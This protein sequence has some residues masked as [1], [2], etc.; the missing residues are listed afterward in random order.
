MKK[1]SDGKWLLSFMLALLMMLVMLPVTCI[2]VHAQ[3]T[4]SDDKYLTFTGTADFKLT[5]SFCEG[6][7]LQYATADPD[8]DESWKPVT[9]GTEI[10]VRDKPYVL[11]LRG[12]DNSDKQ[13]FSYDNHLSIESTGNVA[14]S[15]NIMTL[16]DY[17]APDQAQM[18]A[19]CFSH[20]FYNC[21]ALTAAP[22][23]PATELAIWCYECMFMGCSSL[24]TAP[25]LPA[26]KMK[27]FCYYDM[28]YDCSSL[29]AAPELPATTLAFSCYGNMFCNCSSL[30]A[31]PELRA[32][33]LVESCCSNMFNGCTGIRL[34]ENLTY[35]YDVP[36]CIPSYG[37]ETLNLALNDM[38]KGTGGTFTDTPEPGKTYY[39]KVDYLTFTAEEGGSS[40][41]IKLK[42]GCSPLQY[43]KKENG[44][45]TEWTDYTNNTSITLDRGDNVRFR[46]SDNENKQLFDNK[47]HVTISGKV[48]CSGNI[49]TL[50]DYKHPDQAKI[51]QDCFNY[52]FYGCSSLTAAPA[53]P[54]TE[55]ADDCYWG[56]FGGC[57]S[58][59]A[60]PAL[61]ATE[62][63]KGCYDGMFSGCSSL[64]EVPALPA[65]ELAKW[66]YDGM[67]YGCS[68]LIAAPALPAE[69]LA[70][71]CY[72]QM[73]AGCSSL[74][75]A[76]ALPATKLAKSCYDGMFGG[77]SSL[78]EAPELPATELSE[79]CYNGM[80]YG[81]SS[82]TA[83][84]ALPA[85]ELSEF[86]YS[87]MFSGCSSLTEAPALPA[88]K[89]AKKC[90]Y[91]MFS[92][93]TGI[94]LSVTQTDYFTDEY[95]VPSSGIGTIAENAL[96]GMFYGTGG[97]FKSTPDINTTYYMDI[98][99]AKAPV[100]TTQP[101]DLTLKYGASSGNILGVQAKVATG[102]AVSYQWYS[103]TNSNEDG[104]AIQNATDCCYTIPSDTAIGT[105][106][107]YCVITAT[108]E[109]SGKTAEAVSNVAA[110]SVGK[111]VPTDYSAPIL[112]G[113]SLSF[114]GSALYLIETEGST[115]QG[116]LYYAVTESAA[117]PDVWTDNVS[118]IT[119][120]KTGKF[121]VWYKI[122][123]ENYELTPTKLGEV[124]VT[125]VPVNEI[126]LNEDNLELTVGSTV[127]LTA[128]VTPDNATYP[129]V[130]WTSDKESVA[131]VENGVIKAV[132]AGTATITATAGGKSATCTVTVQPK[133]IPVTGISL[134]EDT[135]ELTVGDTATL[136]ATVAPDDTT[137]PAVTWT[138]DTESVATVENGV[139]TAVSAGTATITATAG[140][141]SATCTVT[142]KAKNNSGYIP[143]TP[144][145]PSDDKNNTNNDGP[146]IVGNGISGWD[147]IAA[148]I[149]KTPEGG[150][151]T[152][153]M[154][155]ATT[156]PSSV[157]NAV[158][159]KNVDIILDMDDGIKWTINGKSVTY[160]LWNI[161][162]GVTV[163]KSGIPVKVINNITGE[164]YNVVIS[165]AHNGPFGFKATL[166]I[167]MRR[168]DAGL[169]ANLFYY[170]RTTKKLEYV[171]GGKIMDDGSVSL[172]FNHASDY[173][174]IVDDHILGKELTAK[175]GR[176]GNVKLSWTA[177]DSAE[178]Y[179]VY[180]VIDGKWVKLGTTTKTTYTVKGLK[181][182]KTCKFMVR[183]NV[184][185]NL[186]AKSDSL[187]LKLKV[188][189][190]PA[191]KATKSDGKLTLTWKE[192]PGA[193]KYRIYVVKND[194]LVKLKNTKLLTY[195]M[196]SKAGKTYRFA[197]KAYVN[198]KWTRIE[199]SDIIKVKVK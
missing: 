22:A 147:N 60:A 167:N 112:T 156:I 110:V 15:G 73:F 69:K 35:E 166:T 125:I 197:V 74:T 163:G 118:A 58:L 6:A 183:Y 70:E 157:L 168:Q 23:L 199:T 172:E 121:Y 180:Q 65:T 21:K 56:M 3:T 188:Y 117:E 9:S 173:T 83:A 120:E 78:T 38:F 12:S 28:F 7:T 39:M 54:A 14:C 5:I 108:R 132:S 8:E 72:S 102:H 174:I 176:T 84:P 140:D 16:L 96:L 178:S 165:L 2:Q 32:T 89:L 19:S 127:T 76:P 162:M 47:N 55:L 90:Y 31:A 189:Y 111:A 142:V 94:K 20:M 62:L 179:E 141:K 18:G 134:D 160:I 79:F 150:K 114:N 36:Y 52:M 159:G 100:I 133:V 155:G 64:T 53:L 171:C 128:T 49:M 25:E 170:N 63:A 98:G 95:R 93:C 146:K 4:G 34:S 198:G 181:N 91:N 138:S 92:G 151:V 164:K 77:C 87:G 82:L 123:G 68:S 148:E 194:K 71:S 107:F 182:N 130:T 37:T 169:I 177:Q 144:S 116:K 59:T 115:A 196:S 139:I 186:S 50:L 187:K 119:A 137:D 145:Y 41:T 161:D 33:T 1:F 48:A 99:L 66:C 30:T 85:T 135:L 184:G 26:I 103:T 24:T 153:D 136:T 191:L 88:T 42:E 75:A 86:C 152:I 44:E 122:V 104:T 149:K 43:S 158:K 45:W 131:T 193:T 190:K 46:G 129:S 105:S 109:V 126:T 154:A 124:T 101:A 27:E 67:F 195:S 192:V 185:G 143:V 57:S 175:V 13:L 97:D 80:F 40:V 29:T 51:G 113:T 106:Y 81:C 61:P 17:N 11:Y 10:E